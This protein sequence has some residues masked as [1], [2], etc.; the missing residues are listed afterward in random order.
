MVVLLT[1][2]DLIAGPSEDHTSF[3]TV[4]YGMR[5]YF[6]V[7]M[8][9]NDQDGDGF[10]EPWQT[11]IGSYK[12]AERAWIEARQWAEAEELRCEK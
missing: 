4:T 1:D 3:V 7:L 9:W 8:W 11:G 10:W 12:T 6:A 2:E 5:G